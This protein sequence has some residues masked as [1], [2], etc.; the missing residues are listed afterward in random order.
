MEKNEV[1]KPIRPT[2]LS[3]TSNYD[4][5]LQEPGDYVNMKVTGS[6]RKV[7]TAKNSFGKRSA[8]KYPSGKI[9]ETISY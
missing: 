4:S 1:T 7:I 5:L 8:V 2:L 6:N 3:E 9:V